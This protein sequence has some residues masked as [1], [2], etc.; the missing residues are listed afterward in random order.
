MNKDLILSNNFCMITKA[1]SALGNIFG[2]GMFLLIFLFLNISFSYSQFAGGTG[3]ET[4]PYLISNIDELQEIKN[5]SN[6]AYFKLIDNIDASITSTWNN[7]DG[8]DPIGW[9]NGQIDGDYHT[10]FDL[11][12]NRTALQNAALITSTG[13]DAVIKNLNLHN[14]T[15]SGGSRVATAVGTLAGS[16]LN[17]TAT[18]TVTGT[19]NIGGL[20]GQIDGG[21][22][23]SNSSFEGNVTGT[24][25]Y[26]GGAIGLLNSN[27]TAYGI[28]V[29]GIVEGANRVGGIAG[30]I[31]S[32]AILEDAYFEGGVIESNN[33]VGGITGYNNSG[34]ILHCTVEADIEGNNR[35]G[36]IAGINEG[37]ITSSSVI[38]GNI[39]GT[40]DYIG[41]LIGNNNNGEIDSC[42]VTGH[43]SGVDYVGG[44]IG[45][46]GYGNSL[47]TNSHTNTTVQ[48]E[49]NVGG[50]VGGNQDGTIELCYSKGEVYG[51][52]N[53]GGLVGWA[54]YGNSKI[55]ISF[56]TANVSRYQ[57]GGNRNQFGGLIG[58][59]ESG[60]VENCFARGDVDANNR[61]GGLIGEMQWS[62]QVSNS[63]STGAVSGTAAQIGGLIGRNHQSDVFNS[64]WDTDSSG[65]SSSDG[66]TPKTTNEMLQASTFLTANWDFDYIWSIDPNINDGY[67]FLRALFPPPTLVWT[68][69]IDTTW[70]DSNNWSLNR[71][72]TNND[73]A[74]IPDRINLPY[75]SSNPVVRELSIQPNSSLTIGSNGTLTVTE[76]ITNKNGVEGLIIISD[77]NGT[78]SLIHYSS[79]IEATFQRYVP[80]MKETWHSL[81]SPMVNHSIEPAFTPPGNYPDGTGYDFYCW[82]EPDTSWIWYG[83]ET[84]W[85]ATHGSLNFIPGRGYLISYEAENPTKEFKGTLNSGSVTVPL[86]RSPGTA[87]QFGYNL[88]GNPYPSSI[89]WKST[90][91][92]DRDMLV[93][94]SGG[95]NIW[96]WNHEEQNYGVY[97]SAVGDS[98]TLGVSRY[99]A[100]TQ[101]FF[102][103]ADHNG[104]LKVN[105][106]A[107]VH[108]GSGNWM[109]NSKSN[110]QLISLKVE[111]GNNK[112]SDQ[113]LVDF[114]YE[115]EGGAEKK[116][117]LVRTAPSLY[118]P[119][120]NRFYTLRMLSNIDDNPVI[121][122]SF[123]A[124][125]NGF[126]S[127]K[128]SFE[129]SSFDYLYLEDKH[130]NFVHD[131][132][133]NPTYHF[134][135]NMNDDPNRFVV[136]FKEGVFANP[137][138][139]LPANIYS[140]NKTIYTDLTLLSRDQT[141]QLN[142]FDLSGRLLYQQQLSGGTK[143][144][145]Y[146]P[147]LNGIFVTRVSGSESFLAVKIHL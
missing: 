135:A 136:R 64:F 109:R 46:N 79:G 145:L 68:G 75:I 143:H 120:S 84:V 80:G 76:Q 98:G 115:T 124:G 88:V 28:S 118:I 123:R 42:S 91:G 56:S 17:I 33:M 144:T 31:N 137:H 48:G 14:C 99:I 78:G 104:N 60:I 1:P 22:S 146:T 94:T 127:I 19:S 57:T 112:G 147:T 65:Q 122:V 24:G 18:G 26:V 89:D 51:I 71:V 70:E 41:G 2:K 4:D 82:H 25:D 45:F 34:S 9:F 55:R 111:S 81:S 47:I 93:E 8:F 106:N 113:I 13:T 29:K 53:V 101:G 23:L 54:A 44:L 87:D 129:K 7:G 117:S 100:P 114:G 27:A 77:E 73:R 11:H 92:W 49:V 16:A 21:G 83:H 10:I 69:D 133:I 125:T 58:Y 96:I 72:P 140:A 103:K 131:L 20:I 108:E 39:T 66:G 5:A 52:T 121:P 138:D 132:L 130:T 139:N 107:R 63:Y 102:V 6:S 35:V 90:S 116:F 3:I 62:A 97:N 74:I 30:Q 110:T 59:L 119:S 126:H 36:G 142:I 105:N 141:Y 95:Y 50:L 32:N 12:I 40:G 67:P 38:D 128:A 134:Q 85:N 86:T 15:I 43:I 61:V 37:T